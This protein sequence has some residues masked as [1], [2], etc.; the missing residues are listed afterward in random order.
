MSDSIPAKHIR[1]CIFCM[2]ENSHARAYPVAGDPDNLYCPTCHM[3]FDK[4]EY[5]THGDACFRAM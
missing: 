5:E 3:T 4:S 2:D 1:P